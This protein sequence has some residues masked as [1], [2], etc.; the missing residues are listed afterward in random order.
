[1][2]RRFLAWFA[3]TLVLFGVLGIGSHLWLSV[4]PRRVA[5]AVDTSFDMKADEPGVERAL[6]RLS[7]TRYAEFALFTD[8][9]RVHG[10]QRELEAA[11]SL[12]FYGPRDLA[13]LADRK[14]F[15]ELS[16]ADRVLVITE[17]SRDAPDLAI[18]RALPGLEL[19]RP[20]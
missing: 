15:P 13:T 14:R 6:E 10:W 7:Q 16:Q 3:A 1:M 20:R 11:P 4:H 9:V 12:S 17:A 19:V 2:V 18:L 5:V 8:K